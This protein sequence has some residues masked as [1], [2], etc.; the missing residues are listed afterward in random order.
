M[1]C[2]KY[3]LCTIEIGRYNAKKKAMGKQPRIL[4]MWCNTGNILFSTFLLSNS[5]TDRNRFLVTQNAVN[6]VIPNSRPHSSS[7]CYKPTD[8][9]FQR[10]QLA[11]GN[12]FHLLHRMIIFH[13]LLHDTTK[14]S[15]H[16]PSLATKEYKNR[17]NLNPLHHNCH[18]RTR[19]DS[20]HISAH[21]FWPSRIPYLPLHSTSLGFLPWSH[22]ISCS[23]YVPIHPPNEPASPDQ[24][25]FRPSLTFITTQ[26]QTLS[27]LYLPAFNP[28]RYQTLTR[29]HYS[30]RTESGERQSLTL[31]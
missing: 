21:P 12:V 2:M 20:L 10:G 13:F 28:L 31:L 9:A 27:L 7:L 6:E 5:S 29:P 3:N 1:S 8:F 11:R 24:L 17:Y 22:I 14:N 19:P 23:S 26:P 30:E 18:N 4:Q 15:S 16:Q 25:R